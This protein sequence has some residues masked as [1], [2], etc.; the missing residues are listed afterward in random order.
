MSSYW[1]K[2]KLSI[3]QLPKHFG[4]PSLKHTTGNSH[5]FAKTTSGK[6]Y[7]CPKSG[8]QSGLEIFNL[9]R[10]QI[11]LPSYLTAQAL[12]LSEPA[13]ARNPSSFW[14]VSIP[15]WPTL[16]S[17]VT[18]HAPWKFLFVILQEYHGPRNYYVKH[19]R[20]IIHATAIAAWQLHKYFSKQLFL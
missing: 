13:S 18:W 19:L 12:L 3:I 1:L 17:I 11:F 9:L 2:P 6:N 16:Q 15:P 10:C 14:L 5:P 8:R 7:H 4:S 20:G